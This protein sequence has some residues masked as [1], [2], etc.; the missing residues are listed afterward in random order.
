MIDFSVFNEFGP[1]YFLFTNPVILFFYQGS[2]RCIVKPRFSYQSTDTKL[3]ILLLIAS[4]SL[5]S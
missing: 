3:G 2:I 4:I 1:R 5:Q